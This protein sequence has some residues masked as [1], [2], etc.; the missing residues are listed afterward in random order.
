[1][2]WSN[3]IPCADCGQAIERSSASEH[4]CDPDRRVEFKM[5]A[6]RHQVLTFEK[7]LHEYLSGKEGRFESWLAARDVRHRRQSA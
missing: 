1:V 2:F 4:T 6:L 3:F 7:E 5:V